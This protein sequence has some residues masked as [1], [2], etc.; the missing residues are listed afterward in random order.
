[1]PRYEYSCDMC[2]KD[3]IIQHLSSET[4]DSCPECHAAHSL[5]RKISAFSTRRNSSSKKKVGKVTEEFIDSA[6]EDLKKEK[7]NLESNR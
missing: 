4:V 6:R 2:S 3:V 5:T 1:M 7:K